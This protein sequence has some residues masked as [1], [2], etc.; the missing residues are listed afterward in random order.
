M[1]KSVLH[2]SS[3]QKAFVRGY[4]EDQDPL[5][6]TPVRYHVLRPTQFKLLD[7]LLGSLVASIH[8]LVELSVFDYPRKLSLGGSNF[9]IGEQPK[10]IGLRPT[11]PSFQVA[12]TEN[13][14]LDLS[15]LHLE[16]NTLPHASA[17]ARGAGR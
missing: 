11:P 10:K 4:L 3:K 13:Q 5:K 6:G 7:G 9:K 17:R 8:S 14:V 15:H 12:L 1:S 2:T 16:P